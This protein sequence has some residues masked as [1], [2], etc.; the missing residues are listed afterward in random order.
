MTDR[1]FTIQDEKV[2]KTK[3]FIAIYTTMFLTLIVSEYLNVFFNTKMDALGISYLGRVRY[4]FKPTVMALYL[5]FSTIVFFRVKS[6][7]K[8]LFNYLNFGKEYTLARKS[9]VRIPWFIIYFQ[10]IVWSLGTLLYYILK[11]WN[12]ES[13]IPFYFGLMSKLATGIITAL[14]L[15]FIINIILQEP[16]QMLNMTKINKG[17][18]D[19]FSRYKDYFA[20]FGSVFYLIVNLSYV[21][22]YYASRGIIFTKGTFLS[23]FL[24]ASLILFSIGIIPIFLGKKEYYFQIKILKE[25]ME[26]IVGSNK[27]FS[28]Q[29]KLINFD[30]LGELA[31]YVNNILLTFRTLFE[32]IGLVVDS[33]SE[34]SKSLNGTS[35]QSSSV[36][37]QQAAATAEIVATME[38]S[39]RL[40]KMI[41]DLAK[42]VTEK[43][44]QVNRYVTEGDSVIIKNLEKNADVKNANETTL[45]FV[46]TLSGDIKSINE[47]VKMINGIADQI[48]IIAFNAELEASAAGEAGKNFEIVAT[49]I[50]RLADSTV[51]STSEIKNRI[52]II[53]KGA[54]RLVDASH[55][56]TELIE[57]SYSTSKDAQD[58]FYKIKNASE[59][60][61][62]SSNVIGKNI[63]MQITGF[64]QILVTIKQIASGVSD[65]AETAS[66][67]SKISADLQYQI[68]RLKEFTTRD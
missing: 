4:A 37:N 15:V 67:V 65:S 54:N 55:S 45:D 20:N 8:P 34:A 17:E 61:V 63:L 44:G 64:E 31:V 42:E 57:S 5:L 51:S 46:E 52:N 27:D 50:R 58:I 24:P 6:Y 28:N 47:V 25:S 66:V 59:E 11:G 1:K 29:I 56:A 16:K 33:L 35:S 14:Y 38:D 9:A 68:D 39:N 49:E 48:K 18:N 26:K 22:F 62:K 53:E 3:I 60:T 10:I 23:H 36:S 32:E 21:A 2:I 12:P 43:F 19:Q 13:G 30:E 7:L 40:S 41:G